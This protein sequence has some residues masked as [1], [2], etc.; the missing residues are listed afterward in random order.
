M[1][2]DEYPLKRLRILLCFEDDQE[3]FLACKH[4]NISVIKVTDK[5]KKE[6]LYILWKKSEFKEKVDESKGTRIPLAPRKMIKTIESKLKG[7]TRLAVCRGQVSGEGAFLDPD[8]VNRIRARQ[9]PQTEAERDA[10]AKEMAAEALKKQEVDAKRLAEAKRAAE[11]R[12][13][14]DE[15][16]ARKKEEEAK[17][18]AIRKERERR[19]KL[20]EEEREANAREKARERERIQ[21]EEEQ[22]ARAAREL[23]AQQAEQKKQEQIEAEKQRLMKIEAERQREQERQEALRKQAEEERIRQ[24]TAL[25]QQRLEELRK[26]EEMLRIDEE[27]RREA[28]RLAQIEQENKRKLEIQQRV[29]LAKRKLAFHLLFARTQYV[30]P[31]RPPNFRPMICPT[32]QGRDM[33]REYENQLA[34]SIQ[35]AASKPSSIIRDRL[36]DALAPILQDDYSQADGHSCFPPALLRIGIFFASSAISHDPLMVRNAQHWI[37]SRLE[38]GSV[39]ECNPTARVA[40]FDGTTQS[41]SKVC[42]G[43]IIVS[44]SGSP[45]S[46]TEITDEVGRIARLLPTNAPCA[47][48]HLNGVRPTGLK[49]ITVNGWTRPVAVFENMQRDVPSLDATLEHCIH[50]LCRT[51][52]GDAQLLVERVSAARLYYECARKAIWYNGVGDHPTDWIRAI[53]VTVE[54]AVEQIHGICKNILS[55]AVSWPPAEFAD[56]GTVRDYF[57]SGENL[58]LDWPHM[59]LCKNNKANVLAYTILLE[60]ESLPFSLEMIMADAPVATQVQL[61]ELL[62]RSMLRTAVEK[63][64]WWRAQSE[65]QRTPCTYFYLPQGS[66]ENIIEQAVAELAEEFP[67]TGNRP[68]D[69]LLVE[70]AEL[71]RE[72][73]EESI[74]EPFAADNTILTQKK[75]GRSSGPVPTD[76]ATGRHPKSSKKTRNS[77]K[78]VSDRLLDSIATTERLQKLANGDSVNMLIGKE[79]RTLKEC[80][81]GSTKLPVLY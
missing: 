5:K 19:A 44:P 8:Q 18:E 45:L 25:E 69:V 70:P 40:F 10:A 57:S 64:L 71:R 60:R 47:V 20:A 23:A 12:K 7:A 6:R 1:H 13:I 55:D 51:V 26:K 33:S 22:R 17:K 81:L 58:P 4:Y 11:L 16:R 41:T 36:S 31:I 67:C 37:F 43:A 54:K 21:Q 50:T 52:I 35:L 62:E 80:F 3:T 29:N 49:S 59:S 76:F 73:G 9:Q 42:N 28:Q 38:I 32:A 14:E 66:T 2:G 79:G 68:S 30:K 34:A 56:G 63:A 78:F 65:E 53:H 75:R 48:L 72:V 39:V 24:Q 27:K 77:E 74:P 15:K 46:Q 61:S